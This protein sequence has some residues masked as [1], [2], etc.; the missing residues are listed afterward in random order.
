M[1]SS[2]DKGQRNSESTFLKQITHL[3][4]H[5]NWHGFCIQML[6]ID[7]VQRTGNITI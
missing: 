7:H 3:L 2:L 6:L 1:T 4:A 5:N